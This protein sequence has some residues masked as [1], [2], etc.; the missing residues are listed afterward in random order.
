[1]PHVAMGH[2]LGVTHTRAHSFSIS[3]HSAPKK[4]D[5]SSVWLTGHRNY[6]TAQH[7]E[8]LTRRGLGA[9]LSVG[10]CHFNRWTTL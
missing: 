3:S 10:H 8:M 1:M 4:Q 9:V 7:C 2:V 5:L 6:K